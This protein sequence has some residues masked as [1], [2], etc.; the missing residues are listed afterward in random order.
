MELYI[1]RHGQSTNNALMDD[2]RFRIYD[3]DLTD[4][5]LQQAQYAAE[6]LANSVNLE[7]LVSYPADSPYRNGAH[8]YAFTHIYCS[9]MKRAMQTAAPIADAMGL[10]PEVWVDIHEHG[11]VFLE[12]DGVVT[13][14]GGMTRS[15]IET[16]FPEYILP[17]EITDHGWWKTDQGKVDIMLCNAR[18]MRVSKALRQRA[19]IEASFDDKVAL[20]THGTFVDA[21]IKALLNLLPGERYYHWHYNTGITRFD[22][23][24]NGMLIVRYINR[25][26][27]LPPELVT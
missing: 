11:G 27:H 9:P 6:Y 15:E 24:K 7:Q 3:P 22:F 4:F 10:I 17:D 18:A 26:S 16:E 20:V 8:H 23:I 25:I 5:G 13:G 19:A 12:E 21:L 2:Q 1:I 14:Y